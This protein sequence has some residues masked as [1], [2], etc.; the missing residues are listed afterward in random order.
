MR[1]I[2]LCTTGTRMANNN[3][4]IVAIAEAGR[5][6]T[7]TRIGCIACRSKA[8]EMSS[9]GKDITEGQECAGGR[10]QLVAQ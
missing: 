8:W 10:D 1:G 6:G 5:G 3:S 9:S 2:V 7:A 4:K